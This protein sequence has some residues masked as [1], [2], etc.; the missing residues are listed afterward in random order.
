MI[1]LTGATGHLGSWIYRYLLERGEKLRVLLLP[2]EHAKAEAMEHDKTEV[3]YGDLG[4]PETLPPFFEN[5]EGA[6]LIHCAGA[7]DITNRRMKFLRKINVEG[8]RALL[9]LAE[10]FGIKRFLY[11][12]S[13]HALPIEKN[14][15]ASEKILTPN[16]SSA[17]MPRPK[18]RRRHSSSQPA[19]KWRPWSCTLRASSVPETRTA[20]I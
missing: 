18:R 9:N 14:P 13:V 1:L 2:S 6:K 7:I 20:G 5:V 3:V 19:N 16:V 12:S 8:T 17:I 15:F 10:K 4:K 11:V